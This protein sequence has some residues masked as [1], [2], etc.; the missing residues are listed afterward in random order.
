MGE[1]RVRVP[2]WSREPEQAATVLMLSSFDRTRL[3]EALLL[4]SEAG[5]GLGLLVRLSC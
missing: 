5:T 4:K 2:L 3:D 1:G